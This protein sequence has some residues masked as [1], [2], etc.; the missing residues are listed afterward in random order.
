MNTDQPNK[1]K[2]VFW[3]NIPCKAM[4]PI[5]A[6]LSKFE[7]ME[8]KVVTASGL[9]QGRKSLH[10]KIPDMANATLEIL[11]EGNWQERAQAILEENTDA[12]H[13]L[14]NYQRHKKLVHVLQTATAMGLPVAAMSEAPCNMSTGIK[15][16]LKALYLQAVLP[17]VLSKRIAAV[18]K[19]FCLSGNRLEAMRRIGWPVEKIIPFGYFLSPPPI[20]NTFLRSRTPDQPL[21]LLCTGFVE[22]FK[23]SGLLVR[24][25]HLLHQQGLPFSC[26]ITG[27]GSYL[28]SLERYIKQHKLEQQVT[29]PG[30]L[31]YEEFNALKK[32]AHVLIAPGYEEPWGIRINEALQE[33][34]PVICSD[35][36]GAADIV[37]AS[38]AGLTFRSGDYGELACCIRQ[39]VLKPELLAGLS[40]HA[41]DFAPR[42]HPQVTAAY[43]RAHLQPQANSDPSKLYLPWG[44]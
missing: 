10:W 13:V 39:L 29:L 35:R 12:T 5:F 30:I 2:V 16:W 38:Q 26:T 24:A 17:R 9:S 25:L 6:E 14:S 34:M 43:L 7:D 18:Q 3:W 27:S 22:E 15:R 33:G 41:L 8:I 42:L 11:E 19:V 44:L 36:L 20:E 31:P 21:H 32:K 23:G 28:P 4:L 40:Q 1:L 37:Q